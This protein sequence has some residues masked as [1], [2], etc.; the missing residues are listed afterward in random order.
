M[1]FYKRV[2]IF[3]LA[4]ALLLAGLCGCSNTAEISDFYPVDLSGHI[5]ETIEPGLEIDLDIDSPDGASLLSEYDAEV[6][7]ADEE[8]MKSFLTYISDPAKIVAVDEW[9]DG[10]HHYAVRTEK[11][12]Y[13]DC[14]QVVEGTASATGWSY[15]APIAD[16]YTYA[17]RDYYGSG[18]STCISDNTNLYHTPK[19]FS[20]LSCEDAE[21]IAR[22]ALDI[23]GLTGLDLVETLYLDHE[24]MSEYVR[25]EAA[26]ELLDHYDMQ[27]LA[28]RGYDSSYDAYSFRFSLSKDR[29]PLFEESFWNT[30]IGYGAPDIVVQ[31]N[32]NGVFAVSAFECSLF[33]EKVSEP[34]RVISPGK[35]L[36][37]VR[38][39]LQDTICPHDRLIDGLKL[40]YIY[41]RDGERLI[42]KPVW[43]ACVL[44]A[45][46]GP[47]MDASN[48]D[49]PREDR[50]SYFIYDAISGNMLCLT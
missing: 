42:L 12:G 43:I 16:T 1:G 5:S 15:Y 45:E 25:S 26:Q 17:V 23:L 44:E 38:A 14:F 2:L 8:T 40:R 11:D 35:V 32:C 47:P 22:E 10:E 29:I 34:S 27:Y 49:G 7:A 46:A 30:T 39:Q 4:E 37:D 24:I 31:I 13:A 28:E 21:K 19:N 50:Y 33:G 3:L 9:L 6:L 48:P 20:F 18:R 36:S 41:W